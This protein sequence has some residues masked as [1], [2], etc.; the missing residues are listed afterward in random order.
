MLRRCQPTQS[1]FAKRIEM[2]RDANMS[3]LQRTRRV[4]QWSHYVLVWLSLKVF[5]FVCVGGVRWDNDVQLDENFRMLWT[6]EGGRDA[7]FE[8]QVRTLGYV[9]VGFSQDGRIPGADVAVGWIHQGQTY[10]QVSG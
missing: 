1:V 8:V 3:P 4:H 5:H 10:F 9:G 6:I 2:S 7:T